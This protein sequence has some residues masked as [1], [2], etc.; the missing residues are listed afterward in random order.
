MD[1]T[2]GTAPAPETSTPIG[3][4]P[5]APAAPS[6]A[7]QPSSP[8][9]TQPPGGTATGA[10]LGGAATTP[11]PDYATVRDTLRNY[12]LDLSGQFQDDHSVLQHLA[13]VYR[14]NQEMQQMAQYGHV[15]LQHADKFQAFLAQQQAEAQKTQQQANQWWKAPEYDPSWNAKLTRDHT[16][17]EIKAVAGADP[18]LVNK[19]L[20]WVDHQRGFLDRFSQDPV[21]AIQP[22]IEQL[23]D[24]RAQQLIQ[25]HLGGYREQTQAQQLVQSN[26][27]W[28]HERNAQGQV[29]RNP[30]TGQPQLS[31]WGQRYGRYVQQAEGFGLR[32]VQAQHDYAV[33]LVQRDYLAQKYSQQ[34]QQ[35]QA[36]SQGD[37]AKEAFLRN[38]G[39]GVHSPGVGSNLAV[40]PNGA[41]AAPPPVTGVRG[42]QELMLKNMAAAGYQPNAM[43]DLN[44]HG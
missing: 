30:Q 14:Q 15:Y 27:E 7:A 21:K 41:P 29:V 34:N 17:G 43:L 31:E 8:S 42:L 20:A 33:G 10:Q 38:G 32:S 36:Q 24:Q 9:A 4:A 22:G 35:Q 2:L 5:S 39:A 23:I 11:A 40:G 3:G 6:P 12:G 37:A 18:G 26:A 25:Q 13:G 44:R 28:L 19:Y 1:P 16:T